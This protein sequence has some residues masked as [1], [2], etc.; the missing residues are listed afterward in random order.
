MKT[1]KSQL[2][3]MKTMKTTKLLTMF[4]LGGVLLSSCSDDDE[5]PDAINEEETITTIIVTLS[6]GMNGDIILRSQDL[7]GDGPNAPVITVSNDLEGNTTYTGSIQFLN[8]TEDPVEDITEEVQDED[9]E[10]Q[11]IYSSTGSIG[12]VTTTDV[13][14]DGNALGLSFELSTNTAGSASITATLR[15]EPTKPN[16]GT[17]A[18]AGGETDAT[19]TF[20][21]LITN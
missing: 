7:D 11:V 13:D 15:H 16:D 4:V 5:N 12:S 18:G 9:D 21:V 20:D 14:G 17:L 1:V 2:L 8:E 19:A 6:G 3:K 10:H